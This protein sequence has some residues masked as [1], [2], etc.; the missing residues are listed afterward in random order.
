MKFTD[1]H[2][3]QYLKGNLSRTA[4]SAFKRKMR[5]DDEFALEVHLHQL[6]I[7]GI[8]YAGFCRNILGEST[9]E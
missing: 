2:I 7:R 1:E 8:R 9:D 5:Q 3:E 6:L 4:A